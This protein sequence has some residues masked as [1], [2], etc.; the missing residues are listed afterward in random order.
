[1]TGRR[2][3]WLMIACCVISLKP[4]IASAV[5]IG[6]LCLNFIVLCWR[7]SRVQPSATIAV[8][9]A[10]SDEPL[11]AWKCAYLT[12][13]Q[14]E[15]FESFVSKKFY[16]AIDTAKCDSLSAP[17]PPHE[18]SDHRCGFYAYMKR[19]KCTNQHRKA[20][21]SVILEVELYGEV[22]EGTLD[23]YRSQFQRVMKVFVPDICAFCLWPIPRP[24]AGFATGEADLRKSP[25]RLL[26]ACH[27]H[28]RKS[29]RAPTFNLTDM[30]QHVGTEVGWYHTIF[31]RLSHV[32]W[33]A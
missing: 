14:P 24:A 19:Q 16:R 13:R 31:S 25:R 7:I 12:E 26:P 18:K 6:L 3:L 15:P 33:R 11:T 20:P 27:K 2:I 28:L 21:Q 17:P 4:P 1:M 30:Q 5:V 9:E 22:I 32:L 23:V 8:T 10:F 29:R